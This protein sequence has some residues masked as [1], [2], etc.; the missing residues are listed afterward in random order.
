MPSTKTSPEIG[1]SPGSDAIRLFQQARA[2]GEAQVREFLAT[3]ELAVQQARWIIDGGDVYP[4]GVRD[5]CEKLSE[6]MIAKAQT[7]SSL[8]SLDAA[9]RTSTAKAVTPQAPTP[10]AVL[11]TDDASVDDDVFSLSA[12][13]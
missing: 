11:E 2:A 3:V 10:V 13:S 12:A 9:A 6:H 7:I 5:A 8:P 1:H 4:A